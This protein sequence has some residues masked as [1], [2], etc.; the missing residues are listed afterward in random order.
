MRDL[1]AL[2]RDSMW[3]TSQEG[4]NLVHDNSPAMTAPGTTP[5]TPQPPAENQANPKVGTSAD[6]PVGTPPR[7]V[8]ASFSPSPATWKTV[9]DG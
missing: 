1:S 6:L 2:A 7:R 4:G 8:D 3:V 9:P 5:A